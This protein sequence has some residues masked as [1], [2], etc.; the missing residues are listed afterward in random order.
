LSAYE[1]EVDN[2]NADRALA[3]RRPVWAEIHLEHLTHNFRTIRAHV[4]AGVKILAA[5]KANAYGH[6]A[7]AVAQYM[8]Q[9]GCDWFGVALPEEGIELRGAGIAQPILCLGGFWGDQAA[10]LLNYDLTPVVYDRARLEKLDA[11][12]HER[13][14][15]A[16]YHLKIDT[17]MGRLGVPYE[18]L[19]SFLVGLDQYRNVKLDG[20]MTHLASAN[21]P[22]KDTLTKKQIERFM[23][24]IE[25]IKATGFR[26]AYYHLAN[27]AGIYGHPEAWGNMV[28]PGGVLY[29][30]WRNVIARIT[31]PPDLK[32]VL[33]LHTR[34]VFLK[35]VPAGTPLGYGGTYVTARL[36]RIATL[37]IG[38]HDGYRRAFSNKAQVIVRGAFAPVVGRVSMDLTLI[39]VTDVPEAT[40]GDEV[41]L[42]GEKDGLRITADEL[43]QLAN[44]ISYEIICGIS[45]RVPRRVV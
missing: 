5:V 14:T 32:P 3:A 11:A 25:M 41:V 26:P 37:P 8:E 33:S 22:A 34:I 40:I 38:Y 17:G 45:N 36:S 42:L 43:A 27:S 15:V 10:S 4:G 6:G 31:P 21:D 30:L 12:A 16:S 35:T 7:V 44:T 24:A 1:F 23:Q 20:L 19:S 13:Q 18:S 2:L 28:R 29:G 39:D 9:L